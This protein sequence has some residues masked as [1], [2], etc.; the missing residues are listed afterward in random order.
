M[1]E[2]PRIDYSLLTRLAFTNLGTYLT[3][4]YDSILCSVLSLKGIKY[5]VNKQG[6]FVNAATLKEAIYKLKL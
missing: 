5:G 3:V 4:Y 1:F 6:I 2:E